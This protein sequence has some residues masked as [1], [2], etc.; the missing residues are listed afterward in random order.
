MLTITINND[1]G[2]NDDDDK[3]QNTVTLIVRTIK[4][5]FLGPNGHPHGKWQSEDLNLGL[6][7]P[8]NSSTC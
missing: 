5:D 2:D 7:D 4:G 6:S 3:L 8:Q 1:D